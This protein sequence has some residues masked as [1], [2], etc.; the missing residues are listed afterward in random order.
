M[1]KRAYDAWKSLDTVMRESNKRVGLT[2]LKYGKNVGGVKIVT[3][4]DS[5][6]DKS[7]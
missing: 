3:A 5:A 6:K 7:K 2:D 4:G 1:T